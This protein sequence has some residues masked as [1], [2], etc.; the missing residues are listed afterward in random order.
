MNWAI[1]AAMLEEQI[2][3]LRRGTGNW[4]AFRNYIE[5]NINEICAETNLR[6]L[7]SICDTYADFGNAIERRNAMM[8][9]V[10][11]KMEK[12]AQTYAYWRMNYPDSLGTPEIDRHRKI[13]LCDGL[14][15]FNLDIGDCPNTMFGRMDDMLS[16][17][18]VLLSILN[19]VKKRL[20]ENDTILGNLN[21]RHGHV[22]E[23]DY[24]WIIDEPY[25]EFRDSGR[26]PQHRWAAFLSGDRPAAVGEG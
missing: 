6:W 3:A 16:E 14:S 21:K 12:I 1:I 10:L 15:S 20:A 8:I 13:R 23:S 2:T 9:S 24:S 7:A 5:R 4:P 19:A 18:P 26:I 11:V 25:R 22:F 17:T